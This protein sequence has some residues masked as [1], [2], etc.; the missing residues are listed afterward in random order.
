MCQ[1]AWVPWLPPSPGDS[2]CRNCSFCSKVSLLEE[3]CGQW[4]NCL[5]GSHMFRCVGDHRAQPITKCFIPK[6]Y[7]SHSHPIVSSLLIFSRNLKPRIYTQW[8][9]FKKICPAHSAERLNP[10]GRASPKALRHGQGTGWQPV[11]LGSMG[12]GV[13]E[14]ERWL[15]SWVMPDNLETTVGSLVFI[16]IVSSC[17]GKVLGSG[18]T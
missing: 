2:H 14:Q 13:G 4:P 17:Y 5:L 15:E 7:L 3:T 11:G 18:M 10:T 12:K 1:N 9:G 16:P 8:L 6:I